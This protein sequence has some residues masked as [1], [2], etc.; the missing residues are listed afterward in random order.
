M[1]CRALLVR[2]HVWWWDNFSTISAW[3]IPKIGTG[4]YFERLWTGV[5]INVYDGPPLDLQ[6]RRR[7]D[8]SI[9][10]IMPGRLDEYRDAVIEGMRLIDR[11]G[12]EYLDVSL[13]HRWDVY[14]IPVKPVVDADRWPHEYE[15]LT[16]GRDSM[17]WYIPFN[18]LPEN[19]GCNQG[20]LTIFRRH[21]V[22]NN[23]LVRDAA[24]HYTIINVDCDIFLRLLKV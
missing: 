11:Q 15:A 23:A 19:I 18:L 22:E 6:V 12:M 20:L 17:D 2:P 24:T 7:A 5:G 4:P 16:T 10:E 9:V 14:N 3:Q 1:V 21:C 8:G 13:V